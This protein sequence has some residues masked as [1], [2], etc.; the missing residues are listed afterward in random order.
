MFALRIPVT[1]AAI[2][3][4]K[5]GLGKA[6]PQVKSSHRIEAA[7]RGLGF[8]SHA[9]MRATVKTSGCAHATANWEP[10][11]DYLEQKGFEVDASRFYT[12]CA[13][14]AMDAAL[15]TV[16]RLT[17]FGIDTGRL[18][19]NPDGS[20]E[21]LAQHRERVWQARAELRDDDGA[22]QFLLSLALM[23]RIKPIKTISDSSSYWVKHI[24]ENY[25]C[26]YPHGTRLGPSYVA[27]GSLIAAAAHAGF[28]VREFP[29]SPNAVFNMSRRSLID[30][31]CEARPTG[32]YAEQRRWKQ[33][34]RAIAPRRAA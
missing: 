27:N 30:L 2:D 11:V 1:L 17:I 23:A 32:A 18:E 7:A 3:T 16:P 6:M 15:L 33:Q 12:S 14:V 22:E 24:A 9:A 29:D 31:D 20:I 21:T 25:T 5:L 26:T 19:R 28:V 34:A 8:Q 13:R 4:I 10:F